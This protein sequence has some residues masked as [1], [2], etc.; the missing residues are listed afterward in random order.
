MLT[1]FCVKF[2]FHDI[3]LSLFEKKIFKFAF[4]IIF[5]KRG[6]LLEMSENANI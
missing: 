3:F 1:S 2:G 4:H 5:F 6:M